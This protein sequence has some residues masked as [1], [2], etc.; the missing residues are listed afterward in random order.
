VSLDVLRGF[1]VMLMVIVNNQVG[2]AYPWLRHAEWDGLQLADFVFPFFLWIMGYA[3]GITFRV[4]IWSTKFKNDEKYGT[5]LYIIP[6]PEPHASRINVYLKIFKRTLMLFFIGIGLHTISIVMRLGFEA[7][8]YVRIPGVLPRIAACYCIS[9]LIYVTFPSPVMQFVLVGALHILYLIIMFGF[10]VPD[11]CGRGKV[12][13]KFC[14]AACWIDRKVWGKNRYGGGS[15]SIPYDPEGLVST[16]TAV[17]TSHLGIFFYKIAEYVKNKSRKEQWDDFT[18]KKKLALYFVLWGLGLMAFSYI[19]HLFL[20]PF[21][22]PIWSSSFAIFTAGFAGF[23]LG[24]IT[25][26]VDILEWKSYWTKPFIWVG[27]N[28]LLLY[29]LPSLTVTILLYTRVS[30]DTSLLGW[31]FKYLIQSWVP[32]SWAAAG[33]LLWSIL[34]ELCFVIFAGIL[35]WKKIYVKV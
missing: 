15:P 33:S 12:W 25:V 14:C 30:K 26:V 24:V 16:L 9:S 4:N 18:Y 11:G 3:V 22:K 35:H 28:P 34:F 32:K 20:F 21:N 10:N 19:I 17:T 27:V 1:T 29:V 2:T 13:D 5:V 23:W 31:L 7:I 6:V 8:P